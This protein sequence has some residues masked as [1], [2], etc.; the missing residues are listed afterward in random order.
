MATNIYMNISGILGNSTSSA[1]P[2]QFEVLSLNFGDLAP[3]HINGR[4]LAPARSR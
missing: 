2:N 4:H 3:H 1:Y